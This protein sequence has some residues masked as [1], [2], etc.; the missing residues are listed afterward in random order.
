MKSIFRQ[1]GSQTTRQIGGFLSPRIPFAVVLISGLI[2]VA[3]VPPSSSRAKLRGSSRGTPLESVQGPPL[4]SAKLP[5][6]TSESPKFPAIP[7]A[8]KIFQGSVGALTLNWATCGACPETPEVNVSGDTIT[9]GVVNRSDSSAQN[10]SIHG[11]AASLPAAGKYTIAF[12][13]DWYTWD[14]YSPSSEGYSGFWD[15]FSVSV[16]SQPYWQVSI[17]D[18]ITKNN[19]SGLGLIWGGQTY[20]NGAFFHTKGTKTL[21]IDGNAGGSNYLNVVLDTRTMP[22]ADHSYPSWG[23]VTMKSII[24]DSDCETIASQAANLATTVTGGAYSYGGKGFTC[25]NPL[26]FVDTQDILTSYF[27]S[28]HVPCGGYDSAPVVCDSAPGVD[29]SGL[30]FWSYN[31]TVGATSKYKGVVQAESSSQQCGTGASDPVSGDL[32]PGDIACLPGHVA[33][34][35]GGNNPARNAVEA[36][37]C[38]AG[39]TWTS[40]NSLDNRHASWRRLKC[41]S[42]YA[43]TVQSHSP[44]S[45]VVTDP[46]GYTISVDTTLFTD[47]EVRHEIPGILYYGRDDVDG[48]VVFGPTLKPGVYRI[49]PV[50]KPDAPTDSTFS[51]EVTGAGYL[52]DLAQ[53]ILVSSIP[54]NGYSI[55]ST[56]DEIT[57]VNPNLT[58][59]TLTL[60]SDPNPAQIGQLITFTATVTSSTGIPTGNVAFKEA[61]NVLGTVSLNSGVATLAIDSITPGVHSIVAEYLGDGSTFSGSVSNTVLQEVKPTPSAHIE[62]LIAAVNDANVPQGIKTSLTAKLSAALTGLQA[63]DLATAC[64]K[65]QDFIDEINAQRGKKIAPSLADSLRN[66]AAQV[67]DDLGCASFAATSLL[68]EKQGWSKTEFVWNVVDI[69]FRSLR[70]ST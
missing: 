45:L 46:E 26:R 56:G 20:G 66:G 1:I 48:D 55:R 32:R 22:F 11:A 69:L 60:N 5:Q 30:I 34:F 9:L 70:I 64:S 49:Q 53:N 19:L 52:L 27:Q 4:A 3:M 40:K 38:S 42:Q 18:P 7:V 51:L 65:L 10:M 33:I 28:H 59:T 6:R 14:A 2:I 8:P 50:R 36:A 68:L 39:I 57:P 41:S 43:L 47:E 44:I 54:P 37:N 35:V 58:P 61:G 21:T 17:S 23:T 13:Y 12:D 62:N 24:T 16:A 31:K 63:E 25:Q 15:S 67:M 29:C